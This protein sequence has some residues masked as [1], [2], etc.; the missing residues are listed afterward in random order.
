MKPFSVLF[1]V[2]ARIDSLDAYNWYLQN[3]PELG[4]SFQECLDAKLKSLKLNPL[5]GS[6]I[7]KN[8]RS[9][10][11]GKFPF[12][13]IYKVSGNQIQIIAIFHNSR[14]PREWRKRI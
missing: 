9:S 5:T 3:S 1:T 11:I 7:Y 13:I 14:N 2:E 8:L 10:K 6:Y 4:K 12:S